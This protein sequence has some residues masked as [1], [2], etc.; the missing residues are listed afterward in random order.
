MGLFN[1]ATGRPHPEDKRLYDQ[2]AETARRLE[3][4]NKET[5]KMLQQN[6]SRRKADKN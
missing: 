2:R 1:P 6:L 3:A 4:Q 5:R